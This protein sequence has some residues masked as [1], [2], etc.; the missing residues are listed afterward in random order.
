MQKILLILI[1]LC[2]SYAWATDEKKTAIIAP[3]PSPLA[4]TSPSK[5][6]SSTQEMTISDAIMLALRYNPNVQTAEIQRVADKYALR[7]AENDFEWHYGLTGQ[8]NYNQ[9]DFYSSTIDKRVAT[10]SAQLDPWA[11]RKT[12]LGT[13]YTLTMRNPMINGEYTPALELNL[14][15]PLLRGFGPTVAKASLYDA[16]DQEIIDKLTLRN[17]LINTVSSVIN[18]YLRIIQQQYNVHTAE[19]AVDSY[20]K[21]IV[22]DNALIKAGR[23]SPTEVVQA[24]AELASE[25]VRL[26]NTKNQLFNSHLDFLNLLG[27]STEI[28]FTLPQDLPP[29]PR[30]PYTVEEAYQV[31]L[32]HN[33]NYQITQLNL[34]RLQ[35]N[36]TVAKD[37]NRTAL[38]LR[39]SIIGA[40]SSTPLIHHRGI[41][42]FA[43]RENTSV[44][45]SLDLE[46]PIDDYGLRQAIVNAQVALDQAMITVNQQKRELRTTI[47]N[48][49]T[50]LKYQGKQIKLAENAL[51]LQQKN[52]H[53][54]AEKL[55]FGL[56]STFEVTSKQ[57][58]LD[59][60]RDALINSKISYWNSLVQFYA[61]MGITLDFWHINIRY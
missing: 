57:R 42:N 1:I 40:N 50:N 46:V 45:L 5:A 30:N 12:G 18:A 41:E 58:E 35:R 37:N 7:V 25:E 49:I 33:I 15:Q 27:L 61:D 48:D 31:A 10:H 54:L 44:N 19:L 60:A 13:E 59:L 47:V 9:T 24:N 52:Q 39:G 53:I 22:L 55:K 8:A 32:K 26:Q 29:I 23:K 17:T 56:V 14:V 28:L 43:T 38:N 16:H 3:L 21:T 11:R 4:L 6:K 36:L 34:R 2:A 20:Q 51:L